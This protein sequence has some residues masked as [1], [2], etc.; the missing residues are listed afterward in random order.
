MSVDL[1]KT[2]IAWAS[3]CI[4]ILFSNK[5]NCDFKRCISF[6]VIRIDYYCGHSTASKSQVNDKAQ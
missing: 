1:G 4:H 2:E 3:S 5:M 6:E